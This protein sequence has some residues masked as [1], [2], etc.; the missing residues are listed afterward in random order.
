MFTFQ[1]FWYILLLPML[2]LVRYILRATALSQPPPQLR[3][4]AWVCNDFKFMDENPRDFKL[5]A[6]GI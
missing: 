5:A 3:F 6:G 1:W 2:L 4:A